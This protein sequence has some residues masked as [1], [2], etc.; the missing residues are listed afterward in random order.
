MSMKQYIHIFGMLSA[1][2]LTPTKASTQSVEFSMTGQPQSFVVESRP[3]VVAVYGAA[4]LGMAVDEVRAVIAKDFPAALPNFKDTIDPL[5]RTRGLVIVV[6]A[7]APVQGLGAATISY[8]FGAQN[9]RL[10]AINVVWLLEATADKAQREKLVAGGT[11]L[12]AEFVGWDWP[13][14]F[15]SSRL[16]ITQ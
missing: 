2:L 15:D 10:M 14:G 12:A 5:T 11:L 3:Y 1:L 16:Q 7:L 13:P 4:R 9:R 8:I 6:P